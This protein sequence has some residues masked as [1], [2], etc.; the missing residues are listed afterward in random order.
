M[1]IYLINKIT[2]KWCKNLTVYNLKY[3]FYSSAVFRYFITICFCL[4]ILEMRVSTLKSQNFYFNVIKIIER[5]S[6]VLRFIFFF[7]G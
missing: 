2:K 6:L 1:S 5:M 4:N 3:S 7:F